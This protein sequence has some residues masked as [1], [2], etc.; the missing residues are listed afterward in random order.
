MSSL[1]TSEMVCNSKH[2]S[3]QGLASEVNNGEWFQIHVPVEQNK[4]VKEQQHQS[5]G[6]G[7]AP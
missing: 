7:A 3:C 1:M 5:D 6:C 2:A 4:C